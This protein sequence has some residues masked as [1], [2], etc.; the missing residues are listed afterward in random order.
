M[1]CNFASESVERECASVNE[2]NDTFVAKLKEAN[3]ECSMDTKLSET[4]AGPRMCPEDVP[5]ATQASGESSVVLPPSTNTAVALDEELVGLNPI[6]PRVRFDMQPITAIWLAHSDY[7]RRS[8][9]VD[10]SKTPFALF[11]KDAVLM[12]S[13]TSGDPSAPL[14]PP[15]PPSLPAQTVSRSS[16][17]T[18]SPVTLDETTVHSSIEA[19]SSSSPPKAPVS[20][21]R[22]SELTGSWDSDSSDGSAGQ[23]DT[24]TDF[25]HSDTE[26]NPCSEKLEERRGSGVHSDGPAFYGYWKKTRS[27][28]YEKMLLSSG[29]PK[30]AVAAALRKHTVHIIDHDGM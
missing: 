14:P 4:E 29:V 26:S 15:G 22:R 11:R 16:A 18:C 23:T 13:A 20:P 5:G 10:L 9:V 30:R 19:S 8:I 2:P 17:F 6:K 1:T 12:K 21:R 27:E 3:S 7:D 24:E 28:G 25:D